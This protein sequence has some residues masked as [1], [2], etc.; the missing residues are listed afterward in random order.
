MESAKLKKDVMEH[1]NDKGISMKHVQIKPHNQF[2]TALQ[3]RASIKK[4]K[5]L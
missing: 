5:F 2:K 1:H 4:S 3:P